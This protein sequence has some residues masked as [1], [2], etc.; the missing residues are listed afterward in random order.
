MANTLICT[1]GASMISNLSRDEKLN[2]YY[3]NSQLEA[4]VNY[5][6]ESNEDPEEFRGFGA[7]I[8]SIAS[9]VKKGYLTERKNL[10]FLVS[11]TDD[12]RK[13]GTILKNFFKV[14]KGYNFENVEVKVISKLRDD[15]PNDFKIHGLRNLIKEIAG[16]IA[17][18]SGEVII[19]ATGGYK[20]QIA[21][22]LALGQ[23]LS[24][25]VYYRFERFPEVI[26]LIPLPIDL[27]DSIYFEA[28]TLFE[29]LENDIKP[30]KE[31]E[32]LY[33]SLSLKSKVFFDEAM[34]DG[35]KY[36]A[37]S[38]MGQIYLE[39][40][41]NKFY[42]LSK[43][44][45]L[46]ERKRNLIFQSSSKEQHSKE[47][48]EKFKLKER[49]EKFK[50]ITKVEVFK[51]SQREKSGSPRVKTNGDKLVVNLPTK[52]GILHF[53]AYTTKRDSRE[54]ELIKIKFEEFLKDIF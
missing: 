23:G 1:V 44:V 7:E 35:K 13:I 17:R 46:V 16:I 24:V 28:K 32:N 4:I 45:E 37:I 8:N 15:K 19:N 21:F 12:G 41:K 27:D 22:A 47:L 14:K 33:K 30:L 20:A 38:P 51:Y 52:L 11:D 10:Y 49:L 48:I 18:H 43:N 26:E 9:I 40:I 53:R 29:E 50:Y 34:I 39:I 36:L 6:S 3:K 42:H 2:E 25:P 31:V 5:F 54:L